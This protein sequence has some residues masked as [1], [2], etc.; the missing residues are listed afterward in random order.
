MPRSLPQE[1]GEQHT[2]IRGKILR[3]EKTFL[4][5]A[6]ITTDYAFT[7]LNK[8]LNWVSNDE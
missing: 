6:I 5:I 1:S 8:I 4:N 7:F 2:E 3:D